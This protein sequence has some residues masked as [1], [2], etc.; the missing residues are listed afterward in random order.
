[1]TGPYTRVSDV[2]VTGDDGLNSP[3]GAD[4]FWDNEHLL[5]HA[6]E[7]PVG[8]ILQPSNATRNLYA[9]EIG[10]TDSAVSVETVY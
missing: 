3:G 7:G 1:M 8:E 6:L 10:V 2:L 4:P 5:F 9:A